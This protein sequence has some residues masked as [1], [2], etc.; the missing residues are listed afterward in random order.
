MLF[1]LAAAMLVF[2]PLMKGGNRP[3][4]LLILEVAAV[5]GLALIAWRG[6]SLPGVLVPLRVAIGLL[7]AVPLL[8]L[9]PL[10]ADLW[11]DLP[12]HAPYAHA[13]RFA[14]EQASAAPRPLSLHPRATE[15]SWLVLMVCLGMFVFTLSQSRGQLHKLARVF[16]AMALLEATLGLMQLGATKDSWMALG[17]PYAGGHATG[18]YVNRNHLAAMLAMALPMGIALWAMETLLPRGQDGARLREHPRHADRRIAR[19]IVLSLLLL[20]I[21]TA[22]LFTS[23]RSGIGSGLLVASLAILTL[24]WRAN[25]L[26]ARIACGA[27]A[28]ATLIFAIYI[29]LT[30]VLERFS[31]G[32]LSLG[33][34]GRERITA[35]AM[36]AGLDFL[37]FGSGLGTFADVFRRYQGE[38]LSAYIDHAHNDYAELFVELGVAGIAVIALAALAYV[39]QWSR[40]WDDTSSRG[41]RRIQVAAGLGM[42]AMIIHAASD[43]N[44][45]IPANAIY[46]AF[47]CGIFFTP[48]VDRE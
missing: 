21:V 32:Q 25:S 35:A 43:F 19:R 36:A 8:Q 33:Y 40:L 3:A 17:N 34:E 7:V 48:A 47:L 31:P 42:L 29:G 39:L 15:Y 14:G 12:G 13:L 6:A 16:V 11:A 46:F 27:T 41:L 4:P 45:H 5:G 37:P 30:P 20:L 28:V 18:T 10:P 44:F 26:A 2:A 23:S 38:G 9:I 1:F 24:V 22:L